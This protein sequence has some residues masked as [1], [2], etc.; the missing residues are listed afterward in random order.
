VLENNPII[1]NKYHELRAADDIAAKKTVEDEQY[2]YNITQGISSKDLKKVLV[3]A[4]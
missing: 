4:Y 3:Y 2:I 1:L